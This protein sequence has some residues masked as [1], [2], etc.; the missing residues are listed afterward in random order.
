MDPVS[1]EDLERPW[2]NFIFS[3]E[4]I[5][6]CIKVCKLFRSY[7]PFVAI[8]REKKNS[9]P[10]TWRVTHA[11]AWRIYIIGFLRPNKQLRHKD[12][13]IANW[14]L[15][16]FIRQT[17]YAKT[18]SFSLLLLW[19]RIQARQIYCGNIY[20]RTWYS[21]N[22]IQSASRKNFVPLYFAVAFLLLSFT[23]LPVIKPYKYLHQFPEQW[24]LKPLTYYWRAKKD[25]FF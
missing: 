9:S 20:L 16:G 18:N 1:P 4:T 3:F 13:H 5:S 7:V 19:V 22:R 12:L 2:L 15:L 10:D 25:G 17:T 8:E 21:L 24:G 23:S 14:K 6:F 11:I